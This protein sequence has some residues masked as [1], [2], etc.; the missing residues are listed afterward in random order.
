MTVKRTHLYSLAALAAGVAFLVLADLQFDAFTLRVLNLSAI[1]IVLAVSLNLV[2]GFTG[3]FSLGHA[4]FMAVGAYTSALLTMTPEQKEVN[5]F[6]EPIAPWLAHLSVPFPLAL[7]AAGC[8]A[9]LIGFLIGAPVLRLKDDY[10]AIATL[11]F[12]EIIR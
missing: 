2:N 6:L 4:G 7:L 1:Y 11:G 12:G 3:L 9:A 8:V 5:F 10:L